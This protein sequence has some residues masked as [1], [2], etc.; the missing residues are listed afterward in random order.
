MK[1]VLYRILKRKAIELIR[2]LALVYG[3]ITVDM[4]L[5]MGEIHSLEYDVDQENIFLHHFTSEGLDIVYEFEDLEEEDMLNIIK[6]LDSFK[7]F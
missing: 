4:K 2:S 5:E 1:V 7:N 6:S 3:E